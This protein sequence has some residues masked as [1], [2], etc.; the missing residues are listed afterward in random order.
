MTID[1]TEAERIFR[2]QWLRSEENLPASKW[3]KKIERFSQLCEQGRTKTHIAFLGTSL[4]AK[5]V[6]LDVDLYAIKPRHAP[7]NPQAYSARSLCH[8]VLVPLSAELGIDIGV[9]GREPL[10]NQPYFRMTR[11]DDGTPIHG[12]S[13]AAFEY[14]LQCWRTFLVLLTRAKMKDFNT[15]EIV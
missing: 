3:Q 2:A 13:R 1:K 14:M 8:T 7:N 9:T 11:L 12:S 10:N 6:D 15:S 5:A 4:L